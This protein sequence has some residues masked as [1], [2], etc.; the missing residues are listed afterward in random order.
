MTKI[1]T[2]ELVG[3]RGSKNKLCLDL[4]D[5]TR[6]VAVFGDNGCG[7]SSITDAIEWFFSNRVDHL[8][9]EDC[10]AQ[11]LR[12]VKLVD[13]DNSSVSVEF[14]DGPPKATRTLN[15]KLAS[16]LVPTA[17]A[18]TEYLAQATSERIILRNQELMHFVAMRKGEKRKHVAEIIG[19]DAVTTF[20]DT[21]QQTLN[22]LRG[23]TDYVAAKKTVETHRA[24]LLKQS[25]EIIASDSAYY[26]V[27]NA[28]LEPFSLS[29]DTKS[30]EAVVACESTMKGRIKQEDKAKRKLKLK[31]LSEKLGLLEAELVTLSERRDGFLPKYHTLIQNLDELQKLYLAEFLK[32]GKS[33]LDHGEGLDGT[34]PFCLTEQ[35]LAA[36]GANVE[37]RIEQLELTQASFAAVQVAMKEFVTTL[38]DV[39]RLCKDSRLEADGSPCSDAF[40]SELSRLDSAALSH[41]D[42]VPTTC[43]AYQ[44]VSEAS[45]LVDSEKE[46]RASIQAQKKAVDDAELQEKLTHEEDSIVE[47]LGKIA[48][49]KEHFEGHQSDT[50]TIEAFET[51]IRTLQTI[52]DEF[53]KVQTSAMQDALDIM[54][55]DI[56]RFY[57]AMHPNENADEVHL[58]ILGEEGVEFRYKF[59][60]EEVHPPMKYL[61]ES[62]LNS[63]GIALFLASVKLFNVQSK[64]FVL[65][66]IISS[67]DVGHRRRL[68]RLLK[69]EFADWQIILLTHEQLWFEL[70]RRELKPDGWIL[71][72]VEWDDSNGT[73]LEQSPA[74]FREFVEQKRMK[75]EDIENDL[76]KLLEQ[77]L[78]ELCYNLRVKVAFRFNEQNE[79]RMPGELLS[80]LQGSV[81]K[82]CST[83]KGHEVFAKLDGSAFIANIGSHDNSERLSSEDIELALQDIDDLDGLF[84]CPDCNV[85]VSTERYVAHDK[86]V[87]CKCGKLSLAW[88]EQ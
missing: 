16:K 80:A 46:I 47:L 14:V 34:C 76:R 28:L 52:F 5:K 26:D 57:T 12:N 41:A 83:L 53:V 66:D 22:T 20:R 78:K 10:Q 31:T 88:K 73:L 60:G 24:E 30:P 38:G 67:F 69:G 58:T 8:W 54:S 18:V 42:G 44:M 39:S 50:R 55:T 49:I 62:H 75:K 17:K 36:L 40:I 35:D 19:Y 68:L 33:V 1:K 70:I 29:L 59:H 63:L 85:V 25:G 37:E 61:S 4:S 65:D 9:R 51:Q 23:T 43:A 79:K 32:K 56:G 15:S 11:A 2:L 86:T 72:Q 3:F 82:K 81:N 27:L 84:R 87:T 74:D 77:N 45:Q 7:K 13:A 64:F 21:I 48:S 71:H 6:S